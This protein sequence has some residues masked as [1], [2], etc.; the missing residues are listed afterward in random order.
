MAYNDPDCS[1]TFQALLDEGPHADAEP[2]LDKAIRA[3]DRAL[4]CW[5]DEGN[6]PD[7]YRSLS[8]K[9]KLA[10]ARLPAVPGSGLPT[11]AFFIRT[12]GDQAVEI[13]RQQAL[14]HPMFAF[15]A[16]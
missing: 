3:Q 5:I 16:Q 15:K 10:Y 11:G 1:N 12:Y 13:T 14:K 4:R 2:L 9:A 7:K 8:K 6:P